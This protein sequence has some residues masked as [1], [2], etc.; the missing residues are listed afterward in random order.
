MAV[1]FPLS[2]WAVSVYIESLWRRA[3]RVATETTGPTKKNAWWTRLV[4][5]E[6]NGGW[7]EIQQNSWKSRGAP[8][9]PP[10]QKTKDY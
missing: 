10:L 7:T 6:K 4:E 1:N 2:C 9:M 8:L 5:R 3:V